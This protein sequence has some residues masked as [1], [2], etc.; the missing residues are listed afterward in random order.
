[1]LVFLKFDMEE[2]L[3]SS[4]TEVQSAMLH[5]PIVFFRCC[6]NCLPTSHSCTLHFLHVLSLFIWACKR[7][8]NTKNDPQCLV[9][10]EER[11]LCNL[12]LHFWEGSGKALEVMSGEGTAFPRVLPLPLPSCLLQQPARVER[13]E[14]ATAPAMIPH[15]TTICCFFRSKWNIASCIFKRMVVCISAIVNDCGGYLFIA[16]V[17]FFST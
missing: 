4:S 12:C 14:S 6:T 5:F 9:T 2:V 7:L 16:S 17:F 11:F 8:C 15:K 3:C 1:M 10:A 13:E